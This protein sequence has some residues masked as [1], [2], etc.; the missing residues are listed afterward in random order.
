MMAATERDANRNALWNSSLRAAHQSLDDDPKILVDNVISLLLPPE[1]RERIANHG[2]DYRD[3]KTN[4]LRVQVVLR[5]R[6]A[7][8]RVEA[9]VGRGVT[10]LVIL[11]AGYDTFPYRLPEWAEKLRVFEVNRPLIQR[12]KSEALAGAGI[13]PPANLTYVSMDFAKQSLPEVLAQAGF[14]ATL[15][16]IVSWRGIIRTLT[17]EAIEDVLRFV[18]GLPR[19]S[20]LVFSFAQPGAVLSGAAEE[21]WLT[22]ISPEDLTGLLRAFGFTVVSFL[23]PEYANLR[24]IGERHDGLLPVETI[25]MGSAL[26]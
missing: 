3:E 14:D 9:A 23:T 1:M 10:Q 13:K 19:E 16:A 25:S 12:L 7:E 21:P 6:F 15:P 24:Y 17:R 2:D 22:R 5:G 8:E 18:G 4:A 26:V 11:G 20:E